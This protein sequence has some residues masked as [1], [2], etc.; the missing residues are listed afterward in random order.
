M[1]KHNSSSGKIF[2]SHSHRDE[3]VVKGLCS[4]IE[5]I[6]SQK[7]LFFAS[8]TDERSF[9]YGKSITGSVKDELARARAVLVLLTENSQKSPWI[10]YEAGAGAAYG[11]DVIPVI[12]PGCRED[13]TFASFRES[14]GIDLR[15]YEDN[16]ID[17]LFRLIVGLLGREYNDEYARRF[18]ER[19]KK[20]IEDKIDQVAAVCLKR[21]AR[22]EPEVLL[23]RS[24]E[25]NG[26]ERKP[27]KQRLF[28]KCDPKINGRRV[29]S[30]NMAAMFA[31]VTEAGIAITILR[32]L[33]PFNHW[34]EEKKKTL[35]IKPL[36]AEP[37]DETASNSVKINEDRDPHWFSYDE[38]WNEVAANREEKYAFEYRRVI[39]DAFE[40][41]DS[42]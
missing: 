30:D 40:A 3:Q 26:N 1:P 33:L 36:L 2:L 4:A 27:G 28:P 20:V 14:K 11:K 7:P 38:A 5:E 22:G 35:C 16:Q 8:S 25:A 39:R 9:A 24:L 29:F 12:L 42:Q 15:G 6:L 18:S 10:H 21:G 34:K 37:I 32:D 13:S 17:N 23:I 31:A 41:L 19:L